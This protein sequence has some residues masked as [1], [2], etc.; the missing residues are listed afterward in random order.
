MFS[1]KF[2]VLL[3][4]NTGTSFKSEPFL[5][6]GAKLRARDALDDVLLRMKQ[7]GGDANKA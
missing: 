6:D 4:A 2:N 3:T 7:Q 5:R 1:F